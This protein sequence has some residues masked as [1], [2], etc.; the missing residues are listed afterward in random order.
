MSARLRWER[1]SA[2]ERRTLR[3]A[4]VVLVPALAYSMVVRPLATS[5]TELDARVDRERGLYNREAGLLRERPGREEGFRHAAAL[6]LEQSPGLFDGRDTVTAAAALV[7]YVTGHAAANRVFVQSS[8]SGGSA[9]GEDGVLRISVEVRAVSDVAGLLA[10]LGALERGQK[11]LR[12]NRLA[13][14]PAAEVGSSNPGAGSE[15]LGL[16]LVV[17]GFGLHEL[18]LPAGSLQM[19]EVQHAQPTAA[20][21]FAPASR[22]PNAA[23]TADP[24]RPE[25]R[26][27]PVPFRMPGEALAG[28]EADQPAPAQAIVLIGTAVASGGGFAMCQIGSEPARLVRLGERLAGYTLRSVGQGRATFRSESGQVI[29][30]RVAK[31]GT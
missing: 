2:R 3:L 9:I 11:L 8:E 16:T 7:S 19:A 15:L 25:R 21:R 14:I 12:V 29:E 5:F 26:P 27:A 22:K 10:W 24:F 30:V 1:L 13:V 20:S 4:A 18:D 31:A 28:T 6:L 17:E 23:L